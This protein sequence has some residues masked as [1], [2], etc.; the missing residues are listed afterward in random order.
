MEREPTSTEPTVL[1]EEQ[2][3]LLTAVLDCLVPPRD[4]LPGA[5]GLGVAGFVERTLGDAPTRRRLLLDGLAA[6]QM[7]SA[8]HAG[9]DFAALDPERQEAILAAIELAA[10]LFFAALVDYTYRG[11]YTHPRVQAA[12]GFSGA[13]AQ[14]RG[15][16]LPVFDPA[17]LQRQR[18]RA[19]FW[20]PT[21]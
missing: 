19:P 14:P 8:R 3:A 10:P 15:F 2:R 13:P 7:T 11:Y 16:A 9:V 12:V 6:I 4:D 20:R 1:S 5:G 17:L 18:Q 21:A